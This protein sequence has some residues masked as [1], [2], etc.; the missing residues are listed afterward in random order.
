MLMLTLMLKTAENIEP[1]ICNGHLPY[2]CGQRWKEGRVG[3]WTQGVGVG[4]AKRL[5]KGRL[6]SLF[7]VKAGV[8]V[9]L[10]GI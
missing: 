10:N 7:C 6:R 5:E 2:P 9:N 4:G 1:T 8:H 3:I